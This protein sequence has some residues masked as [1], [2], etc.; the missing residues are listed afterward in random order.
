[1]K[2]GNVLNKVFLT[3]LFCAIVYSSGWSGWTT[4]SAI[5]DNDF[6]TIDDSLEQSLMVKF[7]PKVYLHVNEDN[8][9]SSIDWYL[10]RTDLRFHHDGGCSDDQ[11]LAQGSVTQAN[12][13]N[14]V[15]STKNFVCAHNSDSISSGQARDTFNDEGYFLQPPNTNGYDAAVHLGDPTTSNWKAYGHVQKSTSIS[16]GYDLQYWVFYPYNDSPSVG[17]VDLNHE[18]DWEHITVTL[19]ATMN[20][21]SA[22]YAAHN[23]EGNRYTTT[24]MQF[25][26]SAGVIASSSQ[27][28]QNDFTHP[29]VYSAV[30]T[31]ASYP[32]AG[33]QVRD[34]LPDDYTSAGTAWNTK[35]A[36]INV[37]EKSYPLNSQTFIKYAGL[38]GEIGTNT[39][40]TGPAGPAFQNAWST[41]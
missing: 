41:Y 26:D 17:G 10:Q 1:M 35:N 18:G 11:I 32:T 34:S 19:D 15:H 24:Q 23:N 20:F 14:R 13:Y 27:K 21:Q 25:A 29:V 9:P 7:A 5:V 16:G 38:W 33:T 8:K 3:V 39:V 40:S 36:V 2:V 37:G 28:L 12:I 22:Y 30:G 31:H 4:A 6:D